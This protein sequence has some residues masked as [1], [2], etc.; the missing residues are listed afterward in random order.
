VKELELLAPVFGES[1]WLKSVDFNFPPA[2]EF[3]PRF[4]I[5]SSKSSFVATC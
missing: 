4:E 2:M 3:P 5:N 1:Q